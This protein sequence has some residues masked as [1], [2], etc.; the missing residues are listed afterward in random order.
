MLKYLFEFLLFDPICFLFLFD[1]Q[2]ILTLFCDLNFYDDL[3]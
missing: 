3:K 2:H 1:L